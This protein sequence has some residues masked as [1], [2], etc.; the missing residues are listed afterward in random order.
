[1]A[2]EGPHM[3]LCRQ[4]RSEIRCTVL[5]PKHRGLVKGPFWYG[6]SNLGSGIGTKIY[7]S[8]NTYLLLNATSASKM[9]A[10]EFNPTGSGAPTLI[11]SPTG[12]T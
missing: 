6:G 11:V 1:M 9:G 4:I 5:P 12:T 2:A 10:E 3:E 7:N 8:K